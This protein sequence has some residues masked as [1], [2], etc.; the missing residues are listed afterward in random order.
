MRIYA[1]VENYPSTYKPYYDAQ[2]GD[3]LRKGHDLTIFAMGTVDRVVNDKVHEFGL[4]QRTKYLPVVLRNVPAHLPGILA[5]AVSLGRHAPQRA[6][7]AAATATGWRARVTAGARALMLPAVAPDLCLIHALATSAHLLWLRRIYPAAPVA[8]YFHGG[9]VPQTPRV[10]DAVARRG[11]SLAD[12]V[13]SN[14]GASCRQAIERGCAPE[15]AAVLPVGFALEDYV[16]PRERAYRPDGTLRLISVGRMTAEKGLAHALEALRQVVESGETRIMY[17][18]V[19]DGYLRPALE[20][21]VRASG[22]EP[23]VRFLGVLSNGAVREALAAA[24]ALLLPSIPSGECAETQACAVQE[25]LLMGALAITTRTG[26]V[27]ES[28]PPEM[29]R[30][31][32]APGDSA[33]LARAI[34]ELAA[35]SPEAMR[36]DAAACRRFVMERYDVAKLNDDLLQRTL[37]AARPSPTPRPSAELREAALRE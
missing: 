20:K 1:F 6:R 23:Y 10:A 19:G 34:T 18:L 36:A 16:L 4:A 14:T 13:F 31:L 28:I 27:P 26:G 7:A 5:G 2:F 15:R 17:T 30:F 8:M 22:L 21:Y 3:F 25:A 32:V 35:M 9:E 12:I 33:A 11:F 24:D 37:L 29:E